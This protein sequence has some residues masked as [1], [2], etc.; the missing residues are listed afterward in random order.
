M[1]CIIDSFLLILND[2]KGTRVLVNKDYCSVP[3]IF[4]VSSLGSI[5][6]W[7]VVK[8]LFDSDHY[9]ISIDPSEN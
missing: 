5:S 4:I 8:E 7:T 2:G 6:R 9:P 1:E 3:D